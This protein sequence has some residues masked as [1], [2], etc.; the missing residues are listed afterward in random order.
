MKYGWLP[1]FVSKYI[2]IGSENNYLLLTKVE[3]LAFCM[4]SSFPEKYVI[5]WC[6]L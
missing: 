3:M 6:D 5:S 2:V 4:E 1:Y